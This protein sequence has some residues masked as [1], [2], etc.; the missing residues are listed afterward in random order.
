MITVPGAHVIEAS[1]GSHHCCWY[2]VDGL[3]NVGQ[4]LDM[5]EY[6]QRE[7]IFDNTSESRH[8][9]CRNIW[10]FVCPMQGVPN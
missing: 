8:W 1:L 10:K 2:W 7:S 3:A 6:V 4:I 5:F 9:Y